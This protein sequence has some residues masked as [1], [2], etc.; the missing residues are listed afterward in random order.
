MCFPNGPDKNAHRTII[1]TKYT[2]LMQILK[3]CVTQSF[4]LF[5]CRPVLIT[6]NNDRLRNSSK[7]PNSPSSRTCT[8][9]PTCVPLRNQGK[10]RRQVGSKQQT[11]LQ[12]HRKDHQHLQQDHQ[13]R[14]LRGAPTLLPALGTRQSARKWKHLRT[15]CSR[16]IVEARRE[17]GVRICQTVRQST[18]ICAI[19]HLCINWWKRFSSRI[20]LQ[21]I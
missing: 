1:E 2:T 14:S 3:Y 6:H 21:L 16:E 20:R 4:S 18:D 11:V 5:V 15:P 19:I 12:V 10:A 17:R 13:D 9:D 7:H 8:S